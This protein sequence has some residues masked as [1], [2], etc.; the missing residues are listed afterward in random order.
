MLL[1][2]S[3]LGCDGLPP[4]DPE[5]KE[6]A[7]GS[8]T[9]MPAGARLLTR[10][11]YRR[12]VQDLLGTELDP[13]VSFPAEPVV[14]GFNNNAKSHQTNPLLVEKYATAA[15]TLAAEVG[16]RG[17]ER[18]HSCSDDS[19]SD[20][21]CAVGL[22]ET[23]G[24]RVFRRPLSRSEVDSF[25][26]LYR[27]AAPSLGH[28]AA[29][30]TLV[31][32]LLQSPQFLYRIEAP[33][34]D[35][36]EGRVALG[37]F[38]LANRL[39]YF[40]W[41]S[42]PDAQLFEAA[43]TGKLDT[44]DRVLAQARRMMSDERAP[45]RI[46]EFHE[47]WLKLD[48][49]NSIA[50]NDAP[51]NFSASLKESMHR[52]ADSVFW[53]PTSRVSDLYSST[54]LF[55]DKSLAELYGYSWDASQEW[56]AIAEADQRHGLLSQ[57]GLMA[58]LAHAD[59]SSPIQRGVFVREHLL[60]EIVVPPPP[61]VNN[62]PPDPAPGLTTRERFA[63]HTESPTCAACHQFIDPLGFGFEA[64][65]QLGRYRTE[66]AGKPVD[67]SG[68]LAGLTEASLERDFDGIEDLASA[69]AD[70]D[71]VLDCLARKWFTFALARPHA[72]EDECSISGAVE[73]SQLEDGSMQ[74]LLIALTGSDAFRFRQGHDAQEDS[75]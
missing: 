29:L 11:E 75:K 31:E 1:A 34:T 67:A 23:F 46:R 35:D 9:A 50:R 72:S 3:L 73:H 25:T 51:A 63:V 7:C 15:A 57:P 71:T 60:C 42:L 54:E 70:S 41:G 40:L 4:E 44:K 48:R 6:A 5:G 69:I 24:Q 30:T 56:T 62:N 45:E 64:F 74:E 53:S 36:E 13:T 2:L 32:A 33:L 43:A 28:D 39:S 21:E 20:E 8:E 68:A 59:Q 66:D 14:D 17:I 26:R 10:S 37:S 27:R 58:L 19:L 18:L 12:T 22:I 55:V 38:E 65:D 16:E 52:F 49:L 47:Q 61:T